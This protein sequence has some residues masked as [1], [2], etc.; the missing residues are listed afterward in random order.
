MNI[1]SVVVATIGISC[2]YAAIGQQP[3]GKQAEK[4]AENRIEAVLESVDVKGRTITVRTGK[5]IDEVLTEKMKERTKGKADSKPAGE[6]KTFALADRHVEVFIKFRSTPS[7]SNNLEQTLAD[8]E[9]M[10][11]YPVALEVFERDG[12]TI[13]SKIVAYRGTPWK[14]VEPK[15]PKKP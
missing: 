6:K 10:I 13:V 3:A 9:K 8:L 4:K 12:K 2:C 5:G 7:G 15:E 11:T 14:I 1:R